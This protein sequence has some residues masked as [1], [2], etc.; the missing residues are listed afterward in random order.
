ML[1]RMCTFELLVTV[2]PV[3]AAVA[4]ANKRLM[5]NTLEATTISSFGFWK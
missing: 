3:V 2:P 5:F 4:A 1:Y